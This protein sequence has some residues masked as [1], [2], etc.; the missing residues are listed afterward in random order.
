MVA[1]GIGGDG[2]AVLA[3]ASP[4][5]VANAAAPGTGEPSPASELTRIDLV[6][7]GDS[8]M[9]PNPHEC[10]EGCLSFVNQYAFYLRDTFGVDSYSYAKALARGVPDAVQ[11]V[12]ADDDGRQTIADAEVVVVETGFDNALPDPASGIGCGGSFSIDWILSTQPECLEQ[13]VAT[14]GQLYDQV[15]AGI[16]ELRAGQPTVMIATTTINGN[17]DASIPDGLLALAGDRADEVKAW[18]VAAYDR[19]NTMLTERAEAAGFVVVDLYHA[20]N[21]PDGGQP[22]GEL[23]TEGTSP[24]GAGYDLIAAMLADVDLDVLRHQQAGSYGRS[25]R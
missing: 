2:G 3:A 14:Y 21:G 9:D 5:A 18:T 12:T 15:F 10:T 13:G 17:I 7:I 1:V 19:W 6:V 23:W 20:F 24:S 22:P 8:L 16:N 11:L 4:A 25:P